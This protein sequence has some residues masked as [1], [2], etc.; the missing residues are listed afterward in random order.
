[1]TQSSGTAAGSNADNLYVNHP[2]HT[3]HLV[4][5]LYAI[6]QQQTDG[7][8]DKQILTLLPCCSITPHLHTVA[9]KKKSPNCSWGTYSKLRDNLP[10]SSLASKRNPQEGR[11]LSRHLYSARFFSESPSI[12]PSTC[13]LPPSGDNFCPPKWEGFEGVQLNGSMS[14]QGGYFT[15]CDF[16]FSPSAVGIFPRSPFAFS[17]QR[18]SWTS[19]QILDQRAAASR[20]PQ[21][22]RRENIN[23][24]VHKWPTFSVAHSWT[25][26]W[27]LSGYPKPS[28]RIGAHVWADDVFKMLRNTFYH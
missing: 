15:E 25:N 16:S 4:L 2:K 27:C 14:E 18:D 24:S 10:P 28:Q 6:L 5:Y 23:P 11:C 26:H 12:L 19:V 9:E 20:W 3:S 17:H 13:P 21:I 1:M 22:I 7:E 8:G